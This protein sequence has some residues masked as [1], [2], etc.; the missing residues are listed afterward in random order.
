MPEFAREGGTSLIFNREHIQPA[1][2]A[3]SGHRGPF[4]LCVYF[5]ARM[6][7]IPIPLKRFIRLLYYL[8]STPRLSGEIPL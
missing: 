5:M 1:K 7:F 4:P 3:F 8:K 6:A 2:K